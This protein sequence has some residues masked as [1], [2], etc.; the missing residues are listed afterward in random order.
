MARMSMT[1]AIGASSFAEE[2]PA[3]LRILETAG[4]NVK[5]NPFRRRLNE[6]E[7]I[8]HLDGVDGL[9]AG[10]E[11][12]SRRVIESAPRLKA[13]ARVGIGVT[14]VDFDA[15]RERGVKVS[16]T[17]EG[18]TEA[19]AEMTLAAML[20]LGRRIVESDR[21]F[22]A[23]EWK[24]LIGSSIAGSIVLFVG[25][26]RI[27]RRTAELVAVLGGKILVYDPYIGDGD[28]PRGARRVADLRDGLREADIVTLHAAGDRCLLDAAM[29]DTM[30]P[31][32]V[33][34]NSARGE[35]VDESALIAALDSGTVRAAWFDAFWKEPYTGPLT[36]YDQVLLTPHV[37]TYTKQCRLSME[38]A[39]VNNLLR[40][41][42]LGAAS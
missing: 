22:H 35:L 31:G 13:I 23:G 11:P 7:I 19:V 25:F 1:V 40:D 5:P 34:L 29:F 10:L 32:A 38:T 3:P 15:A 30:K 21:A 9:I 39:A 8:A 16:S 12:L 2:D 41:L 4:V 24:K 28:V 27:G 26:G 20:A 42:G 18:P 14:N 6:E 36:K 37:A 17:P 33:L